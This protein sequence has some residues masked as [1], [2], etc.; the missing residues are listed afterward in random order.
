MRG[1]KA[2]LAPCASFMQIPQMNVCENPLPPHLINVGMVS[3]SLAF[4]LL[5]DTKPSANK[6]RFCS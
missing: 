1:L 2:E 6:G 5:Y 3:N 4:Y